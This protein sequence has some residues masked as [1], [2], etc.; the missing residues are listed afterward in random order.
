VYVIGGG[1]VIGRVMAPATNALLDALP[2]LAGATVLDAGCGGGE[3]SFV[4]AERVGEAGRVI[5]LDLDAE[6]IE[7][8]RSEAAARGLRNIKFCIADVLEP[9][10]A[11]GA[12]LVLAPF[13]LTHLAQPER[14]LARAR[15][16]MAAG[17]MIAAQDIDYRGRFCDPPSDAFEANLTELHDRVVTLRRQR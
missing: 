8:A 4:L 13:I 11:E 3:A 5:G 1:G 14:M 15:P 6:K 16:A 12:A 7:L 17:G 9:W 10:P 2:S